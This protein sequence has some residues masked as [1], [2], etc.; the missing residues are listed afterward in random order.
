MRKGS[1]REEY[2]ET[3]RAEKSEQTSYQRQRGER[4]EKA[5]SFLPDPEVLENYNY[6]VEGSAERILKMIELEQKHRQQFELNQQKYVGYATYVGA[7]SMVAIC[8]ILVRAFIDLVHNGQQ[9]YAVIIAALGFSYMSVAVVINFRK[10][11]SK[12][13]Y[14]N[15]RFQEEEE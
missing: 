12:K 4:K 13:D 5:R 9:L 2:Q 6:V 10:T 8:Y 1:P 11:S 3:R 15:R 14:K 7:I